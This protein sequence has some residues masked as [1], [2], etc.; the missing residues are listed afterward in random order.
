MAAAAKLRQQLEFAKALR[1][2]RESTVQPGRPPSPMTVQQGLDLGP[3]LG[4]AL[5][6]LVGRRSCAR[7][8]ALF[9]GKQFQRGFPAGTTVPDA[10]Q[11]LL[12]QGP[13]AA[14]P[15]LGHVFS[16]LLDDGK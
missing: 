11:E 5:D 15:A 14:P 16:Q 10:V 8:L 12:G 2:S 3:P 9:F 13:L 7:L 1:R 4:E 6:K